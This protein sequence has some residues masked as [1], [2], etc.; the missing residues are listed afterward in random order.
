MWHTSTRERE[1]ERERERVSLVIETCAS[2]S[3]PACPE[4]LALLTGR[5]PLFGRVVTVAERGGGG[6]EREGGREGERDRKQR[7]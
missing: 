6:G 7:P 2:S 1:R 4:C 5:V 3:L